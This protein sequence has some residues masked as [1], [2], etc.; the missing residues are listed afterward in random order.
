NRV[1][2]VSCAF[3][4]WL[5][6]GFG[7]AALRGRFPTCPLDNLSPLSSSGATK[8]DQSNCPLLT[9]K[10]RVGWERGASGPT[11]HS[12]LRDYLRLSLLSGNP[13]ACDH[14]GDP[15]CVVNIIEWVGPEQYE[16]RCFISLN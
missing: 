8:R 1:S 4:F 7:H 14:C 11:D 12:P 9:A 2:R 3:R 13:T 5:R 6:F 16:I 15:R 10:G